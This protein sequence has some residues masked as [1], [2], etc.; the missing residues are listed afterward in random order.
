MVGADDLRVRA[1]AAAAAAA[2]GAAPGWASGELGAGA[3]PG[4]ASEERRRGLGERGREDPEGGAGR[5]AGVPASRSSAPHPTEPGT[6]PG[7]L[8]LPREPCCPQKPK[9]KAEGEDPKKRPYLGRWIPPP[10]PRAGDFPSWSAHL[11][12]FLVL[13]VSARTDTHQESPAA[14]PPS[15][16][17]KRGTNCISPT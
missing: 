9:G 17:P 6:A 11:G 16:C 7:H 15:F 2:E 12:G 14:E 5:D 13:C 1:A 10:I 3:E 8:W 4:T